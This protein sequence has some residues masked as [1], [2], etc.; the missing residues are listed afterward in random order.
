L[1]LEGLVEL[2]NLV[3]LS[4]IETATA[5]TPANCFNLEKKKNIMDK[6]LWPLQGNKPKSFGPTA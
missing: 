5:C 6:N 4:G 3:T 1:L 2:K